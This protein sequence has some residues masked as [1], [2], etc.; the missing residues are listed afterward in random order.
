LLRCGI[1]VED[2]GDQAAD[3]LSR[4]EAALAAAQTKTEQLEREL[5]H[6]IAAGVPSAVDDIAK[7]AAESQPEITRRLG[8]DGIR[9]MRAE[10]AEKANQLA[11]EISTAQITWPHQQTV[12]YGEAATRHL[13]AALFSYLHGRRMDVLVEVLHRHGFA[14]R[15]DGEHGAQNLVNPHDLYREEWLS[16]LAEARTTL[17]SAESRVRAAKQSDADAVVRSIWDGSHK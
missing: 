17:A 14:I 1:T 5:L 16:P 8:S 6:R 10:L 2:M 3:A 7:G 11:A 9:A 13:D 15:G 12:R 4:A